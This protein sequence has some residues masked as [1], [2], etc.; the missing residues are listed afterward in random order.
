MCYCSKHFEEDVNN[1]EFLYLEVDQLTEIIKD[2]EFNVLSEG[3]YEL[4]QL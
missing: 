1:E 4:F 3:V 2:S